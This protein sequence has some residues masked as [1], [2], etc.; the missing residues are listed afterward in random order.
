MMGAVLCLALKCIGVLLGPLDRAVIVQDSCRRACAV[1]ARQVHLPATAAQDV[2][3]T[4]AAH[5]SVHL[6]LHLTVVA[7]E[8]RI[9][10]CPA[11]LESAAPLE[12]G[13]CH[14]VV[15]VIAQ[16]AMPSMESLCQ[17]TRQLHLH[18]ARH[19][20]LQ[21]IHGLRLQ[22]VHMNGVHMTLAARQW[23]RKLEIVSLQAYAARRPIMHG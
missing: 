16:P 9:S 13:P 5:I 10:S 20:H 8:Q 18:G 3:R 2:D 23:I 15:V 21:G 1:H 6:H 7:R 17:S 11:V 19:P 12:G 22:G 4:L 14:D